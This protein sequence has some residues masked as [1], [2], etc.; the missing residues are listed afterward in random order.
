MN[1][2]EI[3]SLLLDKIESL[4]KNADSNDIQSLAYS[5]EIIRRTEK[6]DPMN[7]IT[8]ILSS[9]LSLMN[10]GVNNDK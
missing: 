8:K 5:Y 1:T 3:K 7:N 6:S 2:K 10:K 4:I 9:N